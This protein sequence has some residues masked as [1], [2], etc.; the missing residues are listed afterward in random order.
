[1]E[2]CQQNTPKNSLRKEK[3]NRKRKDLK[4]WKIFVDEEISSST[5][6]SAA[7]GR[8]KK[9]IC[10]FKRKE[11]LLLTDTTDKLDIS[12]VSE[13]ESPMKISDII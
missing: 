4:L 2:K 7:K 12:F 9:L 11:G 6:T 1:L 10:L 8:N 5:K 3:F 13:Y